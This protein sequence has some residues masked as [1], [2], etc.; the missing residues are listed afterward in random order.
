MFHYIF[1]TLFVMAGVA[2]IFA[3]GLEMKPHQGPPKSLAKMAFEGL[4]GSEVDSVNKRRMQEFRVEQSQGQARIKQLLDRIEEHSSRSKD[5]IAQQDYILEAQKRR[6]QD[7]MGHLDR[8]SSVGADL[9]RLKDAVRSLDGQRELL[10]A[11]AREMQ[12]LN[13][14]I[15]QNARQIKDR[16]AMMDFSDGF[17]QHIS[18]LE[19]QQDDLARKLRDNSDKARQQIEVMEEKLRQMRVAAEGK[20]QALKD[21][22]DQMAAAEDDARQKLEENSRHI[23][24]VRRHMRQVIED[25]KQK[26]RDLNEQ[27]EAKMEDAM[28]RSRQQQED[29]KQRVADQMQRLKDQA[30][31]RN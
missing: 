9:M 12:N 21:K 27:N 29:L 1:F 16:M 31:S 2:G 7:L 8:E 3:M 30:A 14:R 28:Q 6:V 20:S 26:L 23:D 10:I 19:Q 17:P 11:N 15:Y 5:F 22:M 4:G 18:S 24:D 25:N 13:D